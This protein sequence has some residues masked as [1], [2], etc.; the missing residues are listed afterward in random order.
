[1]KC[2]VPGCNRD[3]LTKKELEIHKKYYHKGLV[4]SHEQPQ[5]IASGACP[6][7]GATLFYQEGCVTCQSCGYSKCG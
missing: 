5:R 4:A 1:M 3:G 2:D 6:D 7:C